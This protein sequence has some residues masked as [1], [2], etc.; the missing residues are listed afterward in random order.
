[1]I[2]Q[3]IYEVFQRDKKVFVPDLGAF[4]YSEATYTI[5][6]NAHLT[7]DDGKVIE[8]IQRQKFLS[9]EAA[10]KVLK[11]YVDNVKLTIDQGKP[12]FFGGI[13]YLVKLEDN[14]YVIE[15]TKPYYESVLTS[16]YEKDAVLQEVEYESQEMLNNVAEPSP[17]SFAHE[18]EELSDE[19]NEEVTTD[20]YIA[21]GDY[22]NEQREEDHD[23]SPIYD[24]EM[25]DEQEPEV[26]RRNASAV[27]LWTLLP[28][29]LIGGAVLY[30][31]HLQNLHLP[32][33]SS[34]MK[35]SGVVISSSNSNQL[36]ITER[37]N[38]NMEED[39][40]IIENRHEDDKVINTVPPPVA[41]E[42]DKDKNIEK[43]KD[44]SVVN[45]QEVMHQ[46]GHET[47]ASDAT[48]YSLIL[49]SFKVEDNADKLEQKLINSGLE[50][51]KFEGSNDYYFVGFP[52]IEGKNSAMDMLN[53]IHKTEP[54]AWIIRNR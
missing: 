54:G 53:K 47:E 22:V 37:P 39:D 29:A 18:S 6:F 5:D 52:Q 45:Q 9:E 3:S 7:F 36:V 12:C 19:M 20:E 30:F 10:R 41:V 51:T 48:T 50:V 26:K 14:S 21:E 35:R 8:E 24:M 1:M 38:R 2:D 44:V 31:F 43:L 15:K 11:D 46:E 32:D 42:Q 28:L 17:Y 25:S 49:G 13:G 40:L 16:S 27:L 34:A 23:G 33:V 4:I